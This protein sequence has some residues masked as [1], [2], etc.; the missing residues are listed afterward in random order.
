MMLSWKITFPVRYSA[1]HFKNRSCWHVRQYFLTLFF[2][3]FCLCLNL[4]SQFEMTKTALAVTEEENSEIRRIEVWLAESV[5]NVK[6]LDWPHFKSDGQPHEITAV[7]K[8]AYV[9]IHLPSGK[10]IESFTMGATMNND[11][12]FV[13]KIVLQP[14]PELAK[15]YDDVVDAAE[16]IVQRWEI[17]NAELDTSLS[18]WREMYDS[19]P[20]LLDPDERSPNRSLKHYARGE[21]EFDIILSPERAIH[22]SNEGWY[23]QMNFYAG[24][25]VDRKMGREVFKVPS[26]SS[27]V[28]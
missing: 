17:E 11:D 13:S 20:L 12:G 10:M 7:Q 23:L 25:A 18:K 1:I 8:P 3:A 4:E 6:G 24:Y 9:V 15:S 28:E 27:S 22:Y 5:D 26:T 16:E 19:D 21:I 2:A 14:L